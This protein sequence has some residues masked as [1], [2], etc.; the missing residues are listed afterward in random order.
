M[1]FFKQKLVVLSPLLVLTVALIF[2]LTLVPSINPTP[3]NMPIAIVNEDEGVEIPK[4]GKMNMGNALVEKVQA[5]SREDSNEETIIN[6][7]SISDRDTVMEGLNN[8]E[9][10]AA[11]FIPNDFSQD[12][13][14]LQSPKPSS[15]NIEILINEGMNATAARMA[16][17]ML[18]RITE[19]ISHNV[20]M[21]LLAGFEKQG[22]NIPP[23]QVA[24]LIDPLTVTETNVNAVGTHSANGNAPV[25]F[26]QPLWMS[27]IVGAAIV[28]FSMRKMKIVNRRE[29]LLSKLTQTVAGSLLSFIVG[30]GLTGILDSWLGFHIP[31]FLDTALFVSLS[32]LT[33]FLLISAVTNWFG[34]KGIGVFALLFF[35]GI[36][37]LSMPPEFMSS[38]YRDWIHSWL[39]MRFS[40]EGLRNLLYFGKSLRV[41]GPTLALFN[42]S[43]ISLLIIFVS[44]F[45]PI[46][47]NEHG[48][49]KVNMNEG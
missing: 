19:N 8:K 26:I 35:F 3:K 17:Q 2:S 48:H 23:N 32:Y 20:S 13:A 1:K 40:V 46:P 4:Q 31:N 33:F 15:P 43:W 6:W 5:I 29:S 24:L 27:S 42:I 34:F 14:S 7:I 18:S 36:P 41:D 16:G 38:F 45:K 39:P 37:L 47:E 28:F 9:Y 22:E 10:Y 11:L 49:S 44:A 21:Q 25:S 30:F 12:Q